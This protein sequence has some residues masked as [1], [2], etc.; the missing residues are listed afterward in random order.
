MKKRIVWGVIAGIIVG[1][2][3]WYILSDNPDVIS[4][5]TTIKGDY[6]IE[7]G[8]T[9]KIENNALL[10]IEGQLTLDGQIECAENSSLQLI[11][12]ES[13][14][15]SGEIVCDRGES[16]ISVVVSGSLN[17]SDSFRV[18]SAGN[19]Q[20]AEKEVLLATTQTQVDGRFADIGSDS[21]AGNRVGPLVG[22]G[23]VGIKP[24]AAVISD[25]SIAP[26][27]GRGLSFGIPRAQA[28]SHTVTI[29]GELT[30]PTPAEG[31][32][33]I[34]IFDFPTAAG[35][36]IKDFT[37]KGPDGRDGTDDMGNSCD[38]KATDGED[39][40]RFLAV[41][42]NMTVNNFTLNLGSG[43][44]GGDA[45]TIRDCDP[46]IA[47]GGRGGNSGN[48]KMIAANNFEITG[49]F[50]V[51][52]GRGGD[53]GSA[54]AFGRDGGPTEKG[55]DA[56]AVAGV[57]ADNKKQLSIVG[58]IAGTGNVQFGSMI[59][60]TGGNTSANPGKGGDGN[61]CKS[62]GG[63]GGNVMAATAGKGGDASLSLAGDASRA[64]GA[65]DI[66]GNG[67]DA[68]SRGGA[69]GKGGDCGAEDAGGS[70]GNGGDA[71]ST[72][73]DGGIGTT[74]NG[75]AGVVS[76]ESGGNGGNGGSGCPPGAG[77]TGGDGN[78]RGTDG[79][80]GANLCKPQ[81]SNTSLDEPQPDDTGNV[82]TGPGTGTGTGQSVQVILYNGKY[83][84]IAAQ[85]H[86]EAGHDDNPERVCAGEHW[87]SF[88]GIVTTTDGV[89]IAEPS[90]PCGFGLT[91]QVPAMQIQI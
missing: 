10:T 62:N 2:V 31:V 68:S 87:H 24:A 9:I 82:D 50:T 63:P 18:R 30:V 16:N 91:S 54:I 19:I 66:G 84:P 90:D 46:G 59:G 83:I 17:L 85:L 15:F 71:L 69:G 80:P 4:A 20:F 64:M 51:N 42:S 39:A 73:G 26:T 79:T 41:A 55:G 33:R 44:A 38:A 8:Q 57:G 47:T 29:S 61:G 22:N 34:V 5:D 3:I 76:D 70:G 72:P 21:G 65:E 14:D 74:R 78:P 23:D 37:L 35:V 88:E 67:G 40:F 56:R 11:V 7:A 81:E 60:G 45:E 53:G 58:T 48:F 86:A 12:R 89:Q 77:G 49:A 32:K 43:G 1:G 52:P 25:S 28:D 13:A 27:P 75:E 36:A 6:T